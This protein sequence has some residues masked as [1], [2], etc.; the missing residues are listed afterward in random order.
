MITVQRDILFQKDFS[1]HFSCLDA[2]PKSVVT[3]FNNQQNYNVNTMP[4]PTNHAVVN[5]HPQIRKF[6]SQNST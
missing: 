6:S 5:Q 2:Y 1:N 3:P 4:L